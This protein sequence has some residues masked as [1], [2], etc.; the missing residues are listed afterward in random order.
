MFDFWTETDT[1][2]I[3]EIPIG[4]LEAVMAKLKSFLGYAQKKEALD[5]VEDILKTCADSQTLVGGDDHLSRLVEKYSLAGDEERLSDEE[6]VSTVAGVLDPE[7]RIWNQILE[8]NGG[9]LP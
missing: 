3:S 4:I 1:I 2:K 8:K 6:L 9:F 7:D 5:Q